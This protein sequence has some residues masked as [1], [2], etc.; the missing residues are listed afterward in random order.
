MAHLTTDPSHQQRWICI[1]PAYLN[2]RRT[3]VE[4]RKV[5]KARAVDNPK[6]NEIKDVLT[7]HKFNF[8]VEETKQYPRDSF[9]DAFCKGRVRVQLK[10]S[11]GTP[12][13]KEFTTRK[14][15]LYMLGEMIPKLKGRQT[16]G[17][18]A[19]DSNQSS[20][21]SNKKGKKKR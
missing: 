3:Q 5:S 13:N 17:A 10:N 2:S 9:K 21:S 20:G 7:Y 16:K 19:S 14:E 12:F 4:G 15:I 11:D 8:V 18:T 6:V 1:Y